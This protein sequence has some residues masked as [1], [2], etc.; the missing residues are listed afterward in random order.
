MLCNSL[1]NVFNMVCYCLPPPL[2][3][4]NFIRSFWEGWWGSVVV[5][6]I[7]MNKII[8][9]Q[10][11]T[12]ENSWV[13]VMNLRWQLRCLVSMKWH[14]SKYK[15]KGIL[16]VQVQS[17]T[18]TPKQLRVRL[19]GP[20]VDNL[21]KLWHDQIRVLMIP[22]INLA[23]TIWKTLPWPDSGIDDPSNQSGLAILNT[24][25]QYTEIMSP[26]SI[27]VKPCCNI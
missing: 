17:L 23:W 25:I 27:Y 24:T 21:K 18:T 7:S 5:I 20:P 8:H 14:L 15:N 16:T 19:Y 6:W 12:M 1:H 13:A 3:L 26:G 9:E 22:V 10:T 2:F 4:N 11:I